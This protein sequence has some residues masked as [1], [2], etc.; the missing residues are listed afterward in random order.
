[1]QWK[2]PSH[3]HQEFLVMQTTIPKKNLRNVSVRYRIW[4]VAAGMF[5]FLMQTLHWR[6]N[7]HYILPPGG[8]YF[9]VNDGFM[10]MQNFCLLPSSAKAWV[11]KSLTTR[12]A[13]LTFCLSKV[14]GFNAFKDSLQAYLTI[15]LHSRWCNRFSASKLPWA[16]L[17]GLVNSKRV[18]AQLSDCTFSLSTE[19]YMIHIP[20]DFWPIQLFLIHLKMCTESNKKNKGR[21]VS[22]WWGYRKESLSDSAKNDIAFRLIALL[23]VMTEMTWNPASSRP[24]IVL[25]IRV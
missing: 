14:E 15:E 13:K 18:I 24:R 21:V 9:N 23:S 20:V 8:N 17:T 12:T 5:F 11:T 22:Q 16:M 25:W 1:M 4:S 19:G 2:L 7:V 3:N 6:F 10:P